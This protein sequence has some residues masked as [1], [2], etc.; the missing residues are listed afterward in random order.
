MTISEVTLLP[1]VCSLCT[2]PFEKRRAI[3]CTCG[4]VVCRPQDRACWALHRIE[5]HS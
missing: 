3:Q 5:E 1:V 4:A 2:R